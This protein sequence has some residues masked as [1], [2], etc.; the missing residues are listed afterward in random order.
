[1]ILDLLIFQRVKLHQNHVYQF[2]F[3]YTEYFIKT[4]EHTIINALLFEPKILP[5]GLV[6]YFHGN[7]GNLQRWGNYAPDLTL[8]GYKVLMVDYRGYGKSTGIPSEK[9]L[10]HDAEAVWS[11]AIDNLEFEKLVLYGRS[12]GSSV[13]SYL[14]MKANPNLLILETPFDELKGVSFSIFRKMFAILPLKH[15]FPNKEHLTK[16]NCPKLI[17]HGTKDRVVTLKSAQQLRPLMGDN[18]KFVVIPNGGHNN[19]NKFSIYH[20]RLEEALG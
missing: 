10:Y 1:M 5:K 19:L 11:W 15:K 7:R 17:F 9:H 8:L 14:A 12:L 3:P 18:D 20:N 4:D 13:A 6:I 2:K 16:V